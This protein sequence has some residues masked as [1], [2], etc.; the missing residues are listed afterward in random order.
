[1]KINLHSKICTQC[2]V[3]KPL[4]DFYKR[5]DTGKERANC[6]ECFNARG[7]KYSQ[8]NR[9]EHL[10]R[11]RRASFKKY[12]ITESE[13]NLMMETQQCKCKICGTEL[14][15]TKRHGEGSP[16]HIDHCHES[17]KVRGLLCKKCNTGIGQFNDDCG[18]LAR[19]IQ[20]LMEER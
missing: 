18:L 14:V 9:K 16:A 17:G 4:T 15:I 12:G 20:Y 7:V 11:C 1:M 13:F 2:G 5:S 3:E 8:Q 10:V 6:K 19:A